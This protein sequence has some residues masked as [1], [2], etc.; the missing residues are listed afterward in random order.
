M[1][2]SRD[3]QECS[4]Y[5]VQEARRREP[6][7]PQ[8]RQP[9]CCKAKVQ[10]DPQTARKKPSQGAV[11]QSRHLENSN[12]TP[13]KAAEAKFALRIARSGLCFERGLTRHR[14][15]RDR[16]QSRLRACRGRVQSVVSGR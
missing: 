10:R 3:V 9:A 7:T 2:K 4:G 6:S 5:K 16:S 11:T 13:V 14:G 1:R 15:V 12:H 8:T